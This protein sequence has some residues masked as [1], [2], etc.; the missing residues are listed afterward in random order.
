VR[1]PRLFPTVDAL[2]SPF[3]GRNPNE[4]S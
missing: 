4:S 3:R 2:E 1:I